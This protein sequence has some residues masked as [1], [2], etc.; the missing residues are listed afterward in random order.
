MRAKEMACLLALCAGAC[1]S[2]AELSRRADD[3]MRWA[4]RSAAAG[5][6]R[7]ARAE[8]RKAEYLY[9][10]ASARSFEESTLAPTPPPAPPLPLFD[11]QGNR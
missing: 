4:E 9:Q 6:Y 11:P 10:R 3:Q 8:Q 2:S 5:N 7:E 1:S